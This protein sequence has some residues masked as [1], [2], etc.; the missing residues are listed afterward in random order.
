VVVLQGAETKKKSYKKKIDFFFWIAPHFFGMALLTHVVVLQGSET[1]KAD[2]DTRTSE[3]FFHCT[4]EVFF[5]Q[6]GDD[7]YASALTKVRLLSSLQHTATHCNQLQ[8]TATHCNTLQHIAAHCS[9][10]Q[11]TATHC[12]TL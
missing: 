11:H 10:L 9:T 6:L 5:V 1:K 3:Y 2:A 12:N 8:H 7:L 4:L